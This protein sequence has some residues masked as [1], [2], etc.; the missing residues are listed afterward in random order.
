MPLLIVTK[1]PAD[2]IVNIMTTLL[3]EVKSTSDF[4]EAS[5][6][7]DGI[8]VTDF[9]RLAESARPLEVKTAVFFGMT[10]DPQKMCSP[11]N[12]TL[13]TGD[14]RGIILTRHGDLS[15]RISAKWNYVAERDCD[16]AL[17]IGADEIEY[18][19]GKF[20]SYDTVTDKINHVYVTLK[21]TAVGEYDDAATLASWLTTL[22]TDYMSDGS[23]LRND[24]AQKDFGYLARIGKTY[25]NI[26]ESSVSVGRKGER[27]NVTGKYEITEAG[28]GKLLFNTCAR[29]LSRSCNGIDVDCKTCPERE[30][31][32]VNN[33][34]DFCFGVED[35]YKETKEYAHSRDIERQKELDERQIYGGGEQVKELT[36]EATDEAYE[37]WCDLMNKAYPHLDAFDDSTNLALDS[38]CIVG[39]RNTVAEV[40]ALALERYHN[41]IVEVFDAVSDKVK[42]RFEELLRKQ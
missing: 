38:E 18:K 16:F 35:F 40:Y 27:I 12:K 11:I 25:E 6:G 30:D 37:R 5:S 3:P 33:F 8:T 26:F 1:Q 32:A 7:K 17:P 19:P 15:G 10:A 13:G 42:V 34:S 4:A 21:A 39:I 2:R 9:D 20:A 28:S 29:F 31:F 23:L 22:E 14:T 36:E 24:V 41:R